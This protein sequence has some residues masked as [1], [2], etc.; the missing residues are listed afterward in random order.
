MVALG[1][2]TFGGAMAL[3]SGILLATLPEP[4]PR[5]VTLS[6]GANQLTLTQRF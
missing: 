2:A 4:A 6:V 5:A 1:M 3:T